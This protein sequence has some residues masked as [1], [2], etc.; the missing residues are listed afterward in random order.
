MSSLAS[1]WPCFFLTTVNMKVLKQAN[2]GTRPVGVRRRNPIERTGKNSKRP[3]GSLGIEMTWAMEKMG[4]PKAASRFDPKLVG[5]ARGKVMQ[6]ADI[7]R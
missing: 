4:D 1:G 6:R 7:C 5:Q 2:T 3:R